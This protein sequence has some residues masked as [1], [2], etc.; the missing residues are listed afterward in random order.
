MLEAA[1]TVGPMQKF[2]CDRQTQSTGTYPNACK[3]KRSSC[4]V[5]QE[6]YEGEVSQVQIFDCRSAVVAY[7]TPLTS[8]TCICVSGL[9]S[10]TH[11]ALAQ[12]TS[13]AVNNSNHLTELV[14]RQSDSVGIEDM[15]RQ[16]NRRLSPDTLA[17]LGHIFR[18]QG[19]SD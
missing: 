16:E 19:D 2:M 14:H 6:K 9:F 5:R 17:S 18:H 1:M 11:L 3:F 13:I 7:W 15:H 8:T 12:H 10:T 4:T